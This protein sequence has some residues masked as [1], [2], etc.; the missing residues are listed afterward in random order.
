MAFAGRSFTPRVRNP[1]ILLLHDI[2]QLGRFLLMPSRDLSYL[3]QP[4]KRHARIWR[5]YQ[6]WYDTNDLVA[7]IM[8]TVGSVLFFFESTQTAGTWLF[9]VGS[10]QF[11]IRPGINVARDLHL[12]GV[13][14]KDSKDNTERSPQES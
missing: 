7:G 13:S 14:R 4:S 9:L 1:L 5:N 12:S 10:I 11:I 6:L 3:T 2:R 8:F